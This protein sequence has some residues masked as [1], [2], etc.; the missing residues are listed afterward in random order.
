MILHITSNL[1]R[2]QIRAEMHTYISGIAN[3]NY[4]SSPNRK[5]SPLPLAMHIQQNPHR[6]TSVRFRLLDGLAANPANKQGK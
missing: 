1:M 4:G 3:N 2:Q 6:N 5:K